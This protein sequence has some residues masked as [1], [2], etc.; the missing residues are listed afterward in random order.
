MGQRIYCLTFTDNGDGSITANGTATAS[1]Y[2]VMSLATSK[3][4]FI[5]SGKYT[6]SGCPSG[7]SSGTYRISCGYRSGDIYRAYGNDVGNGFTFTAT[8]DDYSDE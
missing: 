1:V 7:G 6:I 5:K 3:D 2:L 8:S 4:L